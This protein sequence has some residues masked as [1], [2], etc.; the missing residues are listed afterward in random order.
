MNDVNH[1]K[2]G[3][4]SYFPNIYI[5]TP[6]LA[7]QLFPA[8]RQLRKT[9][10]WNQPTG[11]KSTEIIRD[12]KKCIVCDSG[13]IIS[14]VREVFSGLVSVSREYGALDYDSS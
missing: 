8:A 10:L 6:Q 3:A 12:V 11:M 5:L 7:N 4:I 13:E 1:P 14:T 2:F 9:Q